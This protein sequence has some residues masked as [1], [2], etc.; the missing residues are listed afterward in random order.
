MEFVPDTAG[1]GALRGAPGTET[2]LELPSDHRYTSCI[3]GR[4]FRPPGVHGGHAGGYAEMAFIDADDGEQRAPDVLVDEPI[5]ATR[6]RLRLG[7][8]SGCGDPLDRDPGAVLADVLD[9]LVSREAAEH[10]YGVVLTVN[11]TA[12]DTMATNTRRTSKDG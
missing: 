12:V 9:G 2:V 11:G 1:A 10:T 3:E 8:G 7:G 5:G 6:I 4:T